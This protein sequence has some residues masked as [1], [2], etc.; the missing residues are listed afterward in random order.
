MSAVTSDISGPIEIGEGKDKKTIYTGTKIT[1]TT[2]KDGNKTY[3]VEIVK[4]D[5][6][7]GEGG[8]V[9]GEKTDGKINY[10]NKAGDNI[11]GNPEAQKSINSA[12]KTQAKSIEKDLVSTNAESKAYHE[13][14]GNGNEGTE[15]EN[16]QNIQALW[17]I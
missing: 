6:Q 5:N 9:I 11:T 17:E 13:A 1:P 2:D 16:E 12:S 15:S 10:N 8:T 4:Y 14:N 3:K 7:K